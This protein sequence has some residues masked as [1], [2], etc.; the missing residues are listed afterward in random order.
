MSDDQTQGGSTSDAIHLASL[1]IQNGAGEAILSLTVRGGRYECQRVVERASRAFTA[2]DDL[3]DNSFR[4]VLA[5]IAPLLE[6]LL[7]ALTSTMTA[8]AASPA[9]P[10]ASPVASPP[11]PG[12]WRSGTE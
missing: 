5:G 2:E 3:E 4:A 7:T 1:S 6:P 10:V 11:C 9:S 8:T 12:C